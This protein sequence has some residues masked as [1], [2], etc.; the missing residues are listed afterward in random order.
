MSKFTILNLAQSRPQLDSVA[1]TNAT[2]ELEAG[3]VLFL[4]HQ[5]FVRKNTE[6]RFLSPAWWNQ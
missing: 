2:R 6:P 3:N 4:P 5:G 1:A